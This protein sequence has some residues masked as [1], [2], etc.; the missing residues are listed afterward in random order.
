VLCVTHH[1]VSF[2]LEALKGRKDTMS[3]PTLSWRELLAQIIRA[4]VERDRIANEI[5]V[6]SI[7]LVRWTEGT[8]V[9][10]MHNMQQLLL[11]IPAE[12]RQEFRRL[13]Q[14]DYSVDLLTM[15]SQAATTELSLEFVREVLTSR[16]T[17]PRSLRFWTITRQVLR[18]ALRQLDPERLGVA[19]TVVSCI[20][21]GSDGKIHSLREREGMGTPP[22]EGDLSPSALLLGADSL[23]G[24]VVTTS[25]PSM[26][27]DLRETGLVPAY[28]TEYEASAMAAPFLYGNEIAGC[29]LL[30][31]IQ[32]EY[33]AAQGRQQLVEDY[34]ALLALAFEP[35]EFYPLDRIDLRL[36]PPIEV[37]RTYFASFQRRVLQLMRQRQQFTRPQAELLVWQQLEQELIASATALPTRES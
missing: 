28:R 19:I 29:L 31:S 34:T 25:R 14:V 30:S 2:S 9:P 22:W 3:E 23:A 1:S 11:A 36:L 7:T 32:K 24:H 18:H 20:P 5:G 21:P 12:Y 33:F 26:V 15:E 37:Q 10:R 6:R 35:D 4:P 27:P 13:L 16:A 8:S 17:T